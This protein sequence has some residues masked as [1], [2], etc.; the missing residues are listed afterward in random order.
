[1]FAVRGV[2]DNNAL[3]GEVVKALVA[4]ADWYVSL[5]IELV[6]YHICVIAC[7]CM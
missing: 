1:M 4:H 6:D 5:L 7:D 2:F 3:E